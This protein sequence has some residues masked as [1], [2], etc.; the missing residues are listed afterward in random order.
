M[1]EPKRPIVIIQYSCDPFHDHEILLDKEIESRRMKS[2]RVGRH[3][4]IRILKMAPKR[5]RVRQTIKDI[6]VELAENLAQEGLYEDE[7]LSPGKK[8]TLRGMRLSQETRT[9]GSTIDVKQFYRVLKNPNTRFYFLPIHGAHPKD[10]EDLLEQN[11]FITLP[12]K[13]YVI[14][15]TPMNASGLFFDTRLE[16]KLFFDYLTSL[17]GYSRIYHQR[18]KTIL[19]R[20]IYNTLRIWGPGDTLLNRKLQPDRDHQPMQRRSRKVIQRLP[21]ALYR[22]SMNSQMD[23]L[24][25]DITQQQGVRKTT[26]KKGGKRLSRKEK[27]ANWK[28]H[29]AKKYSHRKNKTGYRSDCVGFISY[30]WDIPP[31]TMGGASTRKGYPNSIMQYAKKIRKQDLRHGDAVYLTHHHIM[32]FDKWA[33]KD[34]NS[35]WAYQM[36]NKKDCRGFTYMKLPYPY[37]KTRR[38]EATTYMLLRRKDSTN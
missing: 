35:Y 7:Q 13:M 1:N 12:E 17:T 32:L 29:T 14:T 37:S 33:D 22:T 16:D 5:K 10:Y 31:G 15:V 2:H 28:K 26:R 38:P 11:Y 23:K 36:C 4:A 18:H 8:S 24:Y 21:R 6:E 34:H 30:M 9:T 20:L 19:A 3:N 25:N 27:L